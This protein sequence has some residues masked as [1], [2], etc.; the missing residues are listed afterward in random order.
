MT[1]VWNGNYIQID[2]YST[3]GFENVYELNMMNSLRNQT[4]WLQC[5][6]NEANESRG[7]NVM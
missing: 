2:L 3:R 5:S 7:S 6:D 4:N 1:S